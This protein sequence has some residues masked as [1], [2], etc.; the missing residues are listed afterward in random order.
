[1]SVIRGLLVMLLAA[2]IFAVASAG[3]STSIALDGSVSIV[4]V[5]PNF[6]G[7][8]PSGVADE[9]GPMQLTGLG[10]ADWAYDFGP[11]FV[12]DGRCF[13]VDGTF[14]LTLRSDGS[15][16]SGPLTGVF[17]PRPSGT[18]HNHGGSISFGNPFVE[19]DTIAFSGA[20]GQF[21]GLSGTATFHTLSAGALFSG[22]L[23]GTL[24]G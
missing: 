24:S 10:V 14:T 6:V 13:D 16:I 22:T 21:A 20:T 8:C 4:I 18:G 23:E 12:P 2:G 3:A 9:C 17:C 11:T 19:N 7:Q 5:K 1:M 15:T